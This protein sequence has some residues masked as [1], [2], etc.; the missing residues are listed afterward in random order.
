MK[1]DA[2]VAYLVHL[3]FLQISTKNYREIIDTRLSFP[4]FLQVQFDNTNI[5][6]ISSHSSSDSGEEGAMSFYGF[7]TFRTVALL[8]LVVHISHSR[9]HVGM[10]K[11]LH[12]YRQEILDLLLTAC[13]K[14]IM[15]DST[16]GLSQI[17]FPSHEIV[18]L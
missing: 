14:G 10:M 4:G 17:L 11:M 8:E 12:N 5:A 3:L 7:K 15:V 6:S 1:S 18:L 2:L 13:R 16:H 9:G